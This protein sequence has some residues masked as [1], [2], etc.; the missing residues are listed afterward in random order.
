MVNSMV[1]EAVAALGLDP[2]EYGAPSLRIAG[3]TDLRDRYGMD[4]F[5]IIN[6]RGRWASDIGFIYQRTTTAEMIEASIEMT[7]ASRP[8]HERIMGIAQPARKRR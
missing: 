2:S 7:Y 5:D 3:A 6:S 4:G 1:H 8:E